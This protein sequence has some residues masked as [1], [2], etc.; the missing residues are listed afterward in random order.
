MQR[1]V[2]VLAAA[3]LVALP[4]SA[5]AFV[6]GGGDGTL[7]IKNEAGSVTLRVTNGAFIGRLERGALTIT[8]ANSADGT[9]PI[10]TGNASRIDRGPDRTSYIGTRLR[11]RLI[12]GSF[13]LRVRGIGISLSAVGKGTIVLE[14]S[15]TA[16]DPGSYS[17]NGADYAPIPLVPTV[18]A[19]A[20][21]PGP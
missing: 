14:G 9:G 11:F 17:L 12:G 21:P 20:A 3:A 4:A 1:F 6:R 8:D 2:I 10:V 19:L 5:A 7:S 13:R 16:V 18:F 15:A